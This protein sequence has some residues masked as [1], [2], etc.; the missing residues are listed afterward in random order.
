M[1]IVV[2]PQEITHTKIRISQ[3]KMMEAFGG[4]TINFMS[5]Q[6]EDGDDDEEVDSSL[7]PNEVAPGVRD[8]SSVSTITAT[9]TIT[10]RR[11]YPRT[12]RRAQ[13]R[14]TILVNDEDV[15]D[16]AT[17][18]TKGSEVTQG[19]DASKTKRKTTGTGTRKARSS[20]ATTNQSPSK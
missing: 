15:E 14:D 8:S 1:E 16:V 3:D 18:V 17:V 6:S 10:T 13:D 19:S 5:S 4:K 11:N 9:S 12:A 7:L 2:V 20:K